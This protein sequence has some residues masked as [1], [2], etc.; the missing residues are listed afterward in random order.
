MKIEIHCC[1]VFDYVVHSTLRALYDIV[2]F[3]FIIVNFM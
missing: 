2:Q 1:K 3:N